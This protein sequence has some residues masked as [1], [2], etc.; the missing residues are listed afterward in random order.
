V[1]LLRNSRPARRSKAS[2]ILPNIAANTREATAA[3]TGLLNS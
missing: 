3:N 2:R 1:A